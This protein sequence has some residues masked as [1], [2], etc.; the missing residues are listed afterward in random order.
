LID[1]IGGDSLSRRT[2]TVQMAD[3]K[4]PAASDARLFAAI[5]AALRPAGVLSDL[6]RIIAQLARTPVRWAATD[7]FTISDGVGVEGESTATMKTPA[8]H[9]WNWI[10]SDVPIAQF[11]WPSSVSLNSSPGTYRYD[12]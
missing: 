12:G 10:V 7:H 9:G 3:R 1:T 4:A 5:D 6:S 2:L 11:P 8:P